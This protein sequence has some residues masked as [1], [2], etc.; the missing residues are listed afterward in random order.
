MWG[1]LS[2]HNCMWRAPRDSVPNA[3]PCASGCATLLT[4]SRQEHF[5]NVRDPTRINTYEGLALFGYYCSANVLSRLEGQNEPCSAQRS[6]PVDP[7]VY[8]KHTRRHDVHMQPVAQHVLDVWRRHSIQ[9]QLG[10]KQQCHAAKYLKCTMHC[11]RSALNTVS[12][13][14]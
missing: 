10:K 12:V 8:W 5:M 4:S 2:T 9:L 6:H 7:D 14:S 11:L 13:K 1:L 3:L